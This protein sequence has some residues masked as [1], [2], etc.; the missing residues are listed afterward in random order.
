MGYR[1]LFAPSTKRDVFEAMMRATAS[2]R[3]PRYLLEAKPDVG[4][5]KTTSANMAR[6]CLL[7]C[8]S[9]INTSRMLVQIITIIIGTLGFLLLFA[10]RDHKL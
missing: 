10:K 2:A 7:A 5:K 4:P 1:F 8:N 6:L 9:Y 3:Q